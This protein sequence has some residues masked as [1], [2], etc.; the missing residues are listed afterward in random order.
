M[1]TRNASRR[2][3]RPMGIEEP[4]YAD[5]LHRSPPEVLARPCKGCLEQATLQTS[6]PIIIEWSPGS[7]LIG[8]F[9]WPGSGRVI[10]K[11]RVFEEI[12]KHFNV[13]RAGAV[14]MFQ[15]PRLRVPKRKHRAKP[16]IWLPYE[17]P[18]LVEVIPVHTT[19]AHPRTSWRVEFRC[20]LCGSE[21]KRLDGFEQ[22]G[23]RWDQTTQR[24]VPFSIPREPGK[25]IILSLESIGRHPIFF[26]SELL[27]WLLCTDEF[28]DF[29]EAKKYTNIIFAEYGEIV[30][31]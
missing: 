7:S 29:A 25:G 31:D 16:R 2:V 3:W 23:S 27:P 1:T 19:H 28:K 13:V 22:R 24:L 21:M 8:D 14:E 18:S 9:T 15:D 12:S 11:A 17:G 20:D 30:D 6:Y 5:C 4:L 26:V 10:V